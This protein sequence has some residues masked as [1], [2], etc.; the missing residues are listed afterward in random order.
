MNDATDAYYQRI[1]EGRYMPTIHTQG[2]WND[3]EQHMAPVAGI[4]LHEILRRHP[5]PDLVPARISYEIFGLIL[6][7]EMTIT[8]E[9]VRPGR[10]IELCRATLSIADRTVVIAHVWLLQPHDTT[11]VAGQRMDSL[12]APSTMGPWQLGWP[13]GFIAS[14]DARAEDTPPGRGRGWL[15][16]SV[17]LVE[18]DEVTDLARLVGLSDTA[19]GVRPRADHREWMFPNVDLTLHLLRTPHGEWLGLDTTNDIGPGGLGITSTVLHD[20]DG[21][22]GRMLQSQTVRALP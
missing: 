19:N 6:A 4:I 18:G 9:V 13:G 14:L 7:E 17:S 21:P 12:P 20:I 2:A 8:T 5:R 22:F 3:H 15:R 1:D 16:T 11:A 10:S